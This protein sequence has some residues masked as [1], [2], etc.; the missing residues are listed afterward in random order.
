MH[1]TFGRSPEL[2]EL[3]CYFT[4]FLNERKKQKKPQSAAKASS[5]FRWEGGDGHNLQSIDKGKHR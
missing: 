5:E 1:R 2:K 4:L 3:M